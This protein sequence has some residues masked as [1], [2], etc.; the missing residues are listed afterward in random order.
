MLNKISFLF[1]I[2]LFQH[3]LHN[4]VVIAADGGKSV[5]VSTIMQSTIRPSYPFPYFLSTGPYVWYKNVINKPIKGHAY[6]ISSFTDNNN[7][8]IFIEKIHFG[9]DGCCH[10]IVEFR[11]L[12]LNE[13]LFKQHFPHNSS[14]HSFKL[15]RWIDSQTF[16]FNAYGGNYNL[17]N[18][19][20]EEPIIAE[21]RK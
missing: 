8:R 2:L 4:P 14:T 6:R 10:E 21:V 16:E 12:L 7:I 3:F 19:G 5:P 18:L 11:Q 20:D 17:N 1:V 13:A 15:I 9:T